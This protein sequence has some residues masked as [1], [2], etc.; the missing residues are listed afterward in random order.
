MKKWLW[1]SL[2]VTAIAVPAFADAIYY[3]PQVTGT[4]ERSN[5]RHFLFVK[6]LTGDKLAIYNE[7]GYTPYRLRLNEYGKVRERWTYYEIGKEFIFDQDGSLDEE[8]TVAV[9]HRRQ[10]QYQKNVSGYDEDVPN[11]D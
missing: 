2:L 6:N 5:I 10:W 7:Y 1:A 4:R 3:A 8:H 9:E 11:D